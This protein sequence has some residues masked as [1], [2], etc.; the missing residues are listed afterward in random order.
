LPDGAQVTR[1]E[2]KEWEENS[3][4]NEQLIEHSDECGVKKRK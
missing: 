2:N 4:I 1:G 3:D